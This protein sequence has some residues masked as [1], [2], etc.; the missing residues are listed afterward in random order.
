MS[1]RSRGGEIA[2]EEPDEPAE[3]ARAEAH[4]HLGI[5]ELVGVEV[6]DAQRVLRTVRLDFLNA[7]FDRQAALLARARVPIQV[8]TDPARYRPSD[9]PV[10]LGN[11]GPGTANMIPG[12]VTAR[13]EG[14]PVLVHGV[15]TDLGRVAT[16]EVAPDTGVSVN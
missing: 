2:V 10:V 8:V 16:A 9:L 1:A 14:V 12:L 3:V 11:P 7:Q 13:H 15:A 4:V 6:L 5:E